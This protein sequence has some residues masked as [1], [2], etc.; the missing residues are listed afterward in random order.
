MVLWFTHQVSSLNI[1]C[2]SGL[3]IMCLVSI[4]HVS[5]LYPS[6]VLSLYCMCLRLVDYVSHPNTGFPIICLPSI[7]HVSLVCPFPVLSQ[8]CM[9]LCLVHSVSCLNATCVTSLSVMCLVPK[10]HLWF[11]HFRSCLNAACVSAFS[12]VCLFSMLHA[13]LVCPL[14][15]LSQK[16]MCLWLIHYVSCLNAARVCFVHSVSFRYTA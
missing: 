7:L 8:Y 16:R 3:S 12:I 11:V 10:T 6:Y 9:R 4:L 5:L 14:C 15:V 2:A 1:A 13:S